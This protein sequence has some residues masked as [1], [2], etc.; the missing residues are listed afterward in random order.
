MKIQISEAQ[1]R[2]ISLNEA[3]KKYYTL[4]EDDYIL[5]RTQQENLRIPYGESIDVTIWVYN[6]SKNYQVIS[7]NTNVS[8]TEWGYRGEGEVTFEQY[9]IAP[10]KNGWVKFKLNGSKRKEGGIH[11]SGFDLIYFPQGKQ[12][13]VNIGVHWENIG[14]SNSL[15]ACKL[16]YG[17]ESINN[18]KSYWLKWLSN[19][20]IVEKYKKIWGYS[21]E[22]TESIFKD[23]IKAVNRIYMNYVI[24]PNSTA[25]AYVQSNSFS[26]F[27]KTTAFMPI[28]VNCAE[29]KLN[30][31]NN[32]KLKQH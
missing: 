23:Y 14:Y 10:G 20:T 32:L 29:N 9:P 28:Y 3:E 1:L 13:N 16:I 6:K 27:F 15:E 17:D 4:Y 21:R 19:D 5:V 24:E 12:K 22:K 8:N 11:R 30:Y 18:A 7:V 26:T 25:F 2:V 31:V